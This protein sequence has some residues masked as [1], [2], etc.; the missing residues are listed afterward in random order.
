MIKNSPFMNFPNGVPDGLSFLDMKVDE[1]DVIIA[2][3]GNRVDHMPKQCGK[4]NEREDYGGFI[5]LMDH[6]F[7]GREDTSPTL[8]PAELLTSLTEH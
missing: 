8:Q 6:S 2:N 1:L 5:N 3:E 4:C 7:E